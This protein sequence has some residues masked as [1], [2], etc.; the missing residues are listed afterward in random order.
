MGGCQCS[1]VPYDY[2]PFDIS[3]YRELEAL[4]QRGLVRIAYLGPASS[5][6]RYSLTTRG[7]EEGQR[8]LSALASGVRDY[9]T[10]VYRWQ[11]GLSFAQLVGAMYKAYPRL[12]V[13]RLFQEI[14]RA[15]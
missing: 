5:H 11:R 6:R 9:I 10:E 15:R 7:Q 14:G 8:A 2:G 4:E 13:N 3:V 1:C 12:R